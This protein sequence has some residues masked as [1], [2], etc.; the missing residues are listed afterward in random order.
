MSF[1]NKTDETVKGIAENA[2]EDLKEI[3]Q[4]GKE[5]IKK[6]GEDWLTYIKEHPFQGIFFGLV[7]CFCLRGLI[8]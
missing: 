8:K 6:S 7:A 4:S 3:T 2:G 1:I 5:E